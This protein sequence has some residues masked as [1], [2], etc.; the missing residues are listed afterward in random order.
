MTRD[1]AKVV[2][3]PRLVPGIQILLE[4]DLDPQQYVV[5]GSVPL[6]VIGLREEVGDVD[7]VA[8]DEAWDKLCTVGKMGEYLG[9]ARIVLPEGVE[10][11]QGWLN[12]QNPGAFDA[13]EMIESAKMV[14][15]V[16]LVRLT[17][18]MRTKEYMGRPK[19]ILDLERLTTYL[20]EN[21]L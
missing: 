13:R 15:G 4:Q 6:F 9:D 14:D 16:P 1:Y 18:V 20:C 5:A 10:V 17:D 21:D 11:F 3:S 12:A 8:V 7:V 2:N 19:D